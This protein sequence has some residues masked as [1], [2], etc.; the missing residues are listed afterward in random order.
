MQNGRG[1]A[2]ELGTQALTQQKIQ[3][4]VLSWLQLAVGE[5]KLQALALLQ[6]MCNLGSHLNWDISI[7]QCPCASRCVEFLKPPAFEFHALSK[8]CSC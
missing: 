8:I 2:L 3:I 4:F 5:G 1:Q 7:P 6:R